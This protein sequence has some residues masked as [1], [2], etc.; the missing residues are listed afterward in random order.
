M[1]YA[2][3]ITD[4]MIAAGIDASLMYIDRDSLDARLFFLN[5]AQGASY[6]QGGYDIGFLGWGYTSPIPDFSED[7]SG[8]WA[9]NGVNYALYRNSQVDSLITALYKTTDTPTQVQLSNSIQEQIFHDAPYNWIYAPSN[10]VAEKPSYSAWGNSSLFNEVTFPDIQHWS[11]ASSLILAEASQALNLDP[12]VTAV[13]NNYYALYI[14]GAIMGGALQEI[15][16]RNDSL[17]PGTVQ[18]I[19]SSP[20]NLTW[21]VTIKPGITFQD[22]V[23]VT[24]DDFVYTQYALTNPNLESTS[25]DVNIAN[26]GNYVTFTFY[27]NG[28]GATSLVDDNSNGGNHIVGSWTATSKYTFQFTLP[29]AY[30]FTRQVYCSFAPLPKHIMEQYPVTENSWD[31]APFSKGTSPQTYTWDTTKYGGNGSYISHYGPIG[32]GPYVLTGFDGTTAT[33]QKYNGYWNRTGLESLGQFS[34]NTYTV[35]WIS[36]VNGAMTQLGTGSVNVLDPNYGLAPN[37]TYLQGLGA[38]VFFDQELG[39]QEMGFNMKN[40]VFGTGTGTPL[41][42][43]NPSM[44]AEAARHVRK[45]ISHLIPRN[46]IVDQLAD[47]AGYPAAGPLGPGWGIWYDSSLQPDSY[48]MNAALLELAAA[49]YSTALTVTP[50]QVGTITPDNTF[51]QLQVKVT[52]NGVPVSGATVRIFANQTQICSGL[53][54]NNGFY[55]CN[56]QIT[57][58]GEYLWFA[59]ATKTGLAN[60]Q[61]NNSTLATDAVFGIPLSA[62]WN[63]ISLPLVPANSA[64]AKIFASQI[65]NNQF[66]IAWGFNNGQW[67]SYANGK[68]TLTSIQDGS[69]YWVDVS[70]ATTLYVTGSIIPQT[71][72]PPSYQLSPGWNLVGFKPQPTI[73]NENIAAYLSSINGKYQTNSVWVYDNSSATWMRTDSSYTL[74]PG[75]AIWIYMTAPATLRP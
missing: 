75:Q 4:N 59:T 71:S 60:A 50:S 10:L 73:Q 31:N 44:A 28:L 49:G 24:A 26:L 36:G 13:S 69:G 35:K 20:D 55:S 47:G 52:T 1:Q 2:A 29:S 40:P 15:D 12:A 14:Y 58:Q 6:A 61:S 42:K 66:V 23:E 38:N 45:A 48:D 68:G 33:L 56:L 30:A 54:D 3:N 25:L 62:G 39:W 7:A 18:T 74:E 17:I 34:I 41:G 9:P 43:S 57:G 72:T 65:A 11:G 51:P 5:V 16:A 22:G 37:R 46:Y 67:R 27:N 70:Q 21:T 8:S 64:L 19:S 53:S 32:A 63:L